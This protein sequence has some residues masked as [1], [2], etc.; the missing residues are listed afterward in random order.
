MFTSHVIINMRYMFRHF[1]TIR[2]FE[3]VLMRISGPETEEAAVG[4]RIL[5]NEELHNL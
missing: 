4:M 3:T 5:N 2:V 1:A